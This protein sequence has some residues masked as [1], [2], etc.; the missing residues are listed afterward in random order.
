MTQHYWTAAQQSA[1]RHDIV[2]VGHRNDDDNFVC[3]HV[4]ALA[5][6]H[7]AVYDI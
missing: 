3:I 6:T 7:C 5:V 2:I 1:E 4:T